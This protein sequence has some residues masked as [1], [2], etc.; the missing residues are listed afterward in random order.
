M[1]RKNNEGQ[2]PIGTLLPAAAGGLLI[3]LLL[4]LAGAVLVRQ[5]TLGEGVIAPCA[6]VFLGLGCAAAGFF[7]AKRAPGGKFVWAV[8]AGTLV[9]L[10][11]LAAG[12]ALLDQPVQIVRA[13]V[14]L[15]CALAASALGGFAGANMRKKKRYHHLKK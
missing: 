9:F 15:L 14:S 4:M 1:T 5:G 10:L 3:T 7:A 13:A 6:F 11:L 12:A 8:G 2:S